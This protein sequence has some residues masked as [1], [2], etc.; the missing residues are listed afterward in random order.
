MPYKILI[1]GEYVVSASTSG[2]CVTSLDPTNAVTFSLEAAKHIV[3]KH[4]LL[5][6]DQYTYLIKKSEDN[7][8]C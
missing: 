3:E 5:N 6:H 1:E 7:E 8:S 2:I 4:R